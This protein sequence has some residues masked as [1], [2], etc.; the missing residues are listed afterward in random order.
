MTAKEYLEQLTNM[1]IRINSINRKISECQDRATNT[2][3]NISGNA[4]QHNGETSEKIADNIGKKIDLETTLQKTK[5]AF[6]EFEVR[7]TIEIN[8]IP[9]NLYSGLLFEKYVNGLTWEQVAE[10]IEKD[11]DYTRKDLHSKALACFEEINPENTRI[12]PVI[13]L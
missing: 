1:R 3:V 2:A 11:P 13:T 9:N 7:A 8:R 5:E 6:E 10:V 4:P 12:N